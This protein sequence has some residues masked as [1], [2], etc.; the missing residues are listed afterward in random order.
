MQA[1]ERAGDEARLLDVRGRQF[2]FESIIRPSLIEGIEYGDDA[3]ALRWYPVAK[4]KVI[5]LDP[6][7]QFGQPIIASAGVPTD[8][9]AAAFAAEGADAQRVARIY[10]VTPGAVHAAVG[11]ERRLA[12]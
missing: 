7:V 10:R 8:A 1:V 6:A 12:A 5:V 4:R 9:L 11:F 2:V 3:Q